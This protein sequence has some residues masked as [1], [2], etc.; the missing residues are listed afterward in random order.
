[1][2]CSKAHCREALAPFTFSYFDPIA[3][4]YSVFELIRRIFL[5]ASCDN[6]KGAFRQRPLQLQGLI[7]GR[8]HPRFDF[9]RC[10][11]ND[12]HGLGMNGPTSLLGSVVRKAN[13]SLLISP[14]FTLRTDFHCSVHMPAK[15]DYGL[16]SLEANQTGGFVPSGKCSFSEKLLNGTTQRFSTPSQRRQW[17]DFKF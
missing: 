4:L 7:G 1:M 2:I 12:R 17:G 16:S 11:E 6:F 14:S 3:F 9:L 15:K 8:R 13:R 5:L 10:C